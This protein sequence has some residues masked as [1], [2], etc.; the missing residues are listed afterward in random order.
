MSVDLQLFPADD[1]DSIIATVL[2]GAPIA[3]SSP[4]RLSL[5]KEWPERTMLSFP[6]LRVTVSPT[7][8]FGDAVSFFTQQRQGAP[9]SSGL[10]GNINELPKRS[11]QLDVY[12]HKIFANT[13]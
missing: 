12:T 9:N 7:G 1:G 4:P 10:C 13:K 11:S 3:A 5:S 2:Q 6:F 8:Q